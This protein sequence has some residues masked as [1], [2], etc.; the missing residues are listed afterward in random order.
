MILYTIIFFVENILIKKQIFSDVQNCYYDFIL[1]IHFSPI[2]GK[3]SKQTC[4]SV[5]EYINGF[6]SCLKYLNEKWITAIRNC[7]NLKLNFFF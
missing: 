3:V 5:P 6:K 1:K 7:F 4:L 2:V